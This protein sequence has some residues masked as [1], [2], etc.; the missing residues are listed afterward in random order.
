MWCLRGYVIL[1]LVK[2]VVQI[3]RSLHGGGGGQ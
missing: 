1:M 3:V 2:I